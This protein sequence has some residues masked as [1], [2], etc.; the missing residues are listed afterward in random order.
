MLESYSKLPPRIHWVFQV[1]LYT[2]VRFQIFRFCRIPK[3]KT[4]P[5]NNEIDGKSLQRKPKVLTTGVCKQIHIDCRFANIF[6][7]TNHSLLL[8]TPSG[9]TQNSDIPKVGIGDL[10]FG[11]LPSVKRFLV[12]KRKYL[13]VW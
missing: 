9:G 7:L 1:S 8:D 12:F 4:T 5:C 6:V 11:H 3:V 13:G 2:G 10:S